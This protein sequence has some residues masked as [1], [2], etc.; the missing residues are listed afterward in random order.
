[1]GGQ[2]FAADGFLLDLRGM[3]RVLDLNE[4]RGLIRVQA[5][6]QWPELVSDYLAKGSRWGIAQ[7]QT[8]A[9]T[10]TLG[11]SLSANVHGRG[12]AMKAHRRKRRGIRSAGRGRL[13]RTCSRTESPLLFSLAIGGY[14]L[15]GII[16]EIALRLSPRR[17]LERVVQILGTDELHD[18]FRARIDDGYL[19]GDFNFRSTRHPET[20]FS[21]EYF[22]AIAPR[23]DLHLPGRR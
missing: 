13:L 12:L 22:P 19:Y 7:K 23:S 11:G 21:A 5:G 3:N 1:M 20:S 15:F 8:G 14:G 2:Q 18:A 9:D 16:T 10:L 17:K 4:D 6:I